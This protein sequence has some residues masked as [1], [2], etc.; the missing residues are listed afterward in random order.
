VNVNQE[1]AGLPKQ[2][3]VVRTP[4]DYISLL[5]RIHNGTASSVE[6]VKYESM[7]REERISLGLEATAPELFE[8]RLPKSQMTNY[9]IPDN[10]D[11]ILAVNRNGVKSY[12][13]LS[14]YIKNNHG[15][16]FNEVANIGQ[17]ENNIFS[18]RFYIPGVLRKSGRNGNLVYQVG[19]KLMLG[20]LSSGYGEGFNFITCIPLE[21]VTDS[22]RSLLDYM[23]ELGYG[24]H[25]VVQNL[26]KNGMTPK[27][28]LVTVGEK[29]SINE[30]YI[31]GVVDN[32]GLYTPNETFLN[33]EAGKVSKFLFPR[34]WRMKIF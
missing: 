19:R 16:K 8:G 25:T 32:D 7:N 11:Y 6:R 1:P 31:A 17:D 30:K 20:T 23:A 34:N 12:E 3:T 27:D 10:Y 28:L 13:Q 5:G 22:E 24:G 4:S 15:I 18:D 29:K 14:E 26:I 9:R 21:A 2:D 33:R